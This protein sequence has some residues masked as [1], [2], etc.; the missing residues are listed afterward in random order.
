[1]AV[2]AHS[3]G[4]SSQSGS[5]SDANEK[6]VPYERLV[7]NVR[8]GV[9]DSEPQSDSTNSQPSGPKAE[10]GH[11]HRE[12][13]PDDPQDPYDVH[14]HKKD[15]ILRPI[16]LLPE[17]DTDRPDIT[18]SPLTVPPGF[19]TA[20]SEVSF[21]RFRSE[22][23]WSIPATVLRLGVIPR[24]ELRFAVPNYLWQRVKGGLTGEMEEFQIDMPAPPVE[25]GAEPPAA[26]APTT[27][28]QTIAT[29]PE[30]ERDIREYGVEDIFVGM[31]Y[32][33]GPI[34]KLDIANINEIVI[35][36]GSRALSARTCEP[37]FRLTAGYPIG[38]N[39][40]IGS[41]QGI[42]I[43]ND[44]RGGHTVDWQPTALIERDFNG[45]GDVFVEWAA[46]FIHRAKPVQFMHFGGVK[47]L[48]RNMQL[49]AHFG[50]GLSKEAPR[51]FVAFGYSFILGPLW[52]REQYGLK[53][54]FNPR[55]FLP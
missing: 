42:Y 15:P 28:S 3:A 35:P 14:K 34:G 50:F 2:G 47:P 44:G 41:M 26:D 36:T 27:V 51:A 54:F 10:Q 53:P 49:E 17:I 40:E 37:N 1:M 33:I 4:L 55:R 12:S 24:W 45:K 32:Q 7:Q 8:D 52:G 38:K 16:K 43:I 21:N 13:G 6:P 25:P 31:K 5:T 20:E 39:W 11:I 19:L 48:R 23:A 29:L 46:D 9:K 30:K 22:R 18:D